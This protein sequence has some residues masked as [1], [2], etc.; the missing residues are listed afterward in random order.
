MLED[1]I[2][3]YLKIRGNVQRFKIIREQIKKDGKSSF[4]FALMLEYLRYKGAF[5]EKEKRKTYD[6]L[7]I[8]A[9]CH[10]DCRITDNVADGDSEIPKG[11]ETRAEFVQ[12]KIDF[13]KNLQNDKCENP[14]K[15]P[16]TTLW[17]LRAEKEG[18]DIIDEVIEM[19][20][21]MLWD[22]K[23]I[24]KNLIFSKAELDNHFFKLDVKGSI[25]A[26]LK[27]YQEDSELWKEI[28]PLG[29]AVRIYYNLRDY[30]VDLEKGFINVP[31]EF[32]ERHDLNISE[33][34]DK[35]FEE[36]IERGI[37]L[38]EEYEKNMKNI[39]LKKI[40]EI[41]LRLGFEQPTKNYFTKPS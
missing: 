39:K 24:N 29:T 17:Y 15:F 13:I 38:L 37:K 1:K 36:E 30:K 11:Y 5:L 41:S 34:T 40:T 4:K 19:H 16:L 21:S 33:I 10:N 12:N 25:K 22:A 2:T 18:V 26:A 3:T 23:R 35:W 7:K 31:K 14:Y 6:L 9:F 28:E 32:I 27:L 8:L 20:E